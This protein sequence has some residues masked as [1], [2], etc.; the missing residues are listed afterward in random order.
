[1]N[2][3]IKRNLYR[4]ELQTSGGDSPDKLPFFSFAIPYLEK[5]HKEEAD[6]WRDINTIIQKY[7]ILSVTI[8]HLLTKRI[9]KTMKE[10]FPEY[11][12]YGSS[13]PEPSKENYYNLSM[14]VRVIYEQKYDK[15][16][17]RKNR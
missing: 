5:K 6:S 7:N 9:D 2:I 17:K 16:K 12:N 10:N 8:E 14:I 1:M 3:S 11:A 4:L 13:I 15:E